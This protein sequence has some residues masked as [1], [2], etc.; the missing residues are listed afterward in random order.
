MKTL[1]YIFSH[2]E[3]G[4][5]SKD[6]NARVRDESRSLGYFLG[7][8]LKKYKIKTE[9]FDGIFFEGK[10]EP[11]E[12]YSCINNLLVIE[13]EFLEDLYPQ[14]GFKK[15]INEYLILR[16]EEGLLKIEKK[17]PEIVRIISKGIQDF[18]EQNYQCSWIY[19]R[20]YI[21]QRVVQLRCEMDINI[22]HLYLD[23]L[24]NN[25]EILISKLILETLPNEYVFKHEFKEMIIEENS[26]LVSNKL[27]KVWYTFNIDETIL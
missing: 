3:V 1:K 24:S 18:R 14:K 17:Y 27:D 25:K 15:E 6:N 10:K 26:I 22:F 20:K 19:K 8:T 2:P 23:I 16:I 4:H 21:S 11:C 12:N 13:V 7:L 5:W 9:N